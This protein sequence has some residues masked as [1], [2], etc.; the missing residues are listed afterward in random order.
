MLRRE[1]GEEELDEHIDMTPMVDVV[2]QLTTF[3]L[4]SSQMSGGEVVDVGYMGIDIV[5]DDE[6]G[7]SGLG[8]ESVSQSL[9][10]KFA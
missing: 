4:L 8:A 10:K 7:L 3:M 2:F 5:A 1:S 9:A 6:V